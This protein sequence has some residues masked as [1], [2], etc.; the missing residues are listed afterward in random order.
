MH[1]TEAEIQQLQ[2]MFDAHLARA[3]KHMRNIVTPKRRLT[4]RQVV[5]YLRARSTSRSPP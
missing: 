3:N 4:A 5:T 2:E 1:E